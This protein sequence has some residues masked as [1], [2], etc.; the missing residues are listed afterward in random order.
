MNPALPPE[1]QAGCER[2]PRRWY[3]FLFLFLLFVYGYVHQGFGGGTATTRVDLLF[4]LF[5]TG[6]VKIDAY[7]ENTSD[8]CHFEGHYYS[9][10]APGT[11]AL[12]APGFGMGFLISE[13]LTVSDKVRWLLCSWFATVSS[14]GVFGAVAGVVLFMWL[15]TWVS[16]RHAFI[17]LLALCLGGPFFPYATILYSHT[18]V[19]ALLVIALFLVGIRWRTPESRW[20]NMAEALAGFCC[21]LAIACEYSAGIAAL[22]VPLMARGFAR[23]GLLRFLLSALLPM[24][25]IPLYQYLCFGSPFALSYFSEV[26]FVRHLSGF[27][28]IDFPPKWE[29]AYTMLFSARRGLF[30]WTPF[31]LL[32]I[33]G[34]HSLLR[35]SARWFWFCYLVP[36]VQVTIMAGYWDVGAGLGLGAR[37]LSPIVPFLAVPAALGLARFPRTGG[38]LAILSIL[39]TGLGTIVSAQVSAGIYDPVRGI[40]IPGLVHGVIAHN[41]GK[42]IGLSPHLSIALL[43]LVSAGSILVLWRGIESASNQA[44]VAARPPPATA[45]NLQMGAA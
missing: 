40:H 25:M 27:V 14:C 10:K 3:C 30:Y 7:H 37:L 34:M 4:S 12:A 43:S 20:R 33:V 5:V 6:S 36:L 13:L 39:L 21:G 41:L 1:E 17:T 22:A 19:M 23:W 42:C 18:I 26:T 31:L 32:A 2:L 9:D 16:N 15:R 28:G 11:V 38:V 44:R 8:K 29:N 35:L 24:A 45:N